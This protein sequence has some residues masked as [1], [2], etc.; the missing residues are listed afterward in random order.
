MS[1][2][3]LLV[4]AILATTSSCSGSDQPQPAKKPT[5]APRMA[6]GQL[7]MTLMAAAKKPKTVTAVKEM[8]GKPVVGTRG[9]V[10][11]SGS[12]ALTLDVGVRYMFVITLDD[13]TMISLSAGDSSP[14]VHAW[15]P[16]GNSVD[17]DV[18]LDFGS[19][20]IVNNIFISTTILLDIDW[21]ED[22]IADFE[23]DD[24]D[25]DGILD[26]VD[27]DI[28]GDGID[29]D[30]LDADGDG[31]VDL[32]DDDDDNDGIDDSDDLDDDGDGVSDSEEDDAID[33]DGDGDIDEGDGDADEIC[34]DGIDNDGDGLVDDEDED[35]VEE[36]VEI[37]DD[38][39][40]N[41]G[42]GQVDDED[43]DCV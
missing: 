19:V 41:D 17:G 28:D 31:N 37:C 22:G 38:G 43:A 15:L 6:K 7:P 40:D 11:A 27:L 8:S 23:D 20:T 13:G 32:V 35:C 9:T 34:D 36:E 3:N 5:G 2:M 1:K 29:D 26:L 21:D 33:I 42:D 30:Y 16:I 4:A 14:K 10:S 24:D 18:G 12:F 39:I 25:N